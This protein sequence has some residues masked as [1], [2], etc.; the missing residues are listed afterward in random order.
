VAL[1]QHESL[2]RVTDALWLGA[3]EAE[4]SPGFES[5]V[6]RALA[7]QRS[8]AL[9][10]TLVAAAAVLLL[11]A[12]YVTG[13]TSATRQL[14]AGPMRDEHR[15]VVGH[16]AISGGAGPYVHV[17]VEAWGGDGEYWV[18]VLRHD[19]TFVRVAPIRLA[20]GRGVASG[21]LP[22]PYGDVRAVWVTDAEHR[23]WCAFRVTSGG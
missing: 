18:E 11:F 1:G 22:V 10:W 14:A 7:P 20:G 3:P 2:A 8:R 4:P 17:A 13:S 12:G 9:R 23:E 5:R 19:R 16:A 6:L 15:V 21:P